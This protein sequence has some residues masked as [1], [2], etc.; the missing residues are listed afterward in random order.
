ME[1]QSSSFRT[2]MKT[3][4]QKKLILSLIMRVAMDRRVWHALLVIIVVY[5]VGVLTT[6]YR[7]FNVGKD[8]V[9][10]C[11]QGQKPNLFDIL[12]MIDLLYGMKK[13]PQ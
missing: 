4:M 1:R 13:S 11:K 5:Q 9:Q 6:E 2:K 12:Y 7:L 8:Y 10:V 3:I